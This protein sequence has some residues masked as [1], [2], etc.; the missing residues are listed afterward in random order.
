MIKCPYQQIGVIMKTTVILGANGRLGNEALQAFAKTDHKVIAITRNA[1]VRNLP[2][3]V[4]VR[5]ADILNQTQLIDATKGADIIVN[6]AHPIYTKWTEQMMLQSKNIL[7]AAKVH[8][9]THLFPGNIYSYGAS[10]PT[11]CTE[12][13]PFKANTKKGMI[14]QEVEALFAHESAVKTVIIRAGDFYGGTGVGS[15]FDLVVTKKLHKGIF[16]YPSAQGI[17][18]AWAYLPDLANTFVKMTEHLDELPNF[19]QWLFEGHTFTSQQMQEHIEQI[20][21][22]KLK[23]STV[24][25]KLLKCIGLVSP[26]MREVCEMAY[27]W[28]RPHSL[29][30]SKLSA[31]LKGVPNTPPNRAIQKAILQLNQ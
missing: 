2:R 4:E 27:L 8:K 7:A 12:K 24:P 29:N 31:L 23:S 3:G 6:M 17:P 28:K 18:H 1:E 22:K 25:W 11:E 15:W 16:T 19:S 5:A 30:G 21:G 20:L 26:M 10:M 13:T 14:R 9:A